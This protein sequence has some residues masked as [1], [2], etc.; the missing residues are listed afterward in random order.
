MTFLSN[1]QNLQCKKMFSVNPKHSLSSCPLLFPDV[2]DNVPFFT[3]SIYEAS[4]TE[5]AESGTLVFQVSANDLDL[6]LNGKVKTHSATHTQAVVKVIMLLFQRGRWEGTFRSQFLFNTHTLLFSVSL[7]FSL[8]KMCPSLLCKLA[9]I[10]C[11]SAPEPVGDMR[12]GCH[13]PC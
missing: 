3:S 1:P 4:V 13:P 12:G 2:N 8:S 9:V 5:G 6:G 11:V 7:C 10:N